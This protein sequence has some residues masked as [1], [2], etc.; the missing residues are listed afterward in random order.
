V[1][2]LHIPIMNM[3]NNYCMLLMIMFGGMK[4]IALEE[5]ADFATLD[6]KKLFSKLKS[7]ELSRKGRPNHDSSLTSKALITSAH[8]G[9]H[10]ANPANNISSSLEFSLLSLTATSDEQYESIPDDEIAPLARK[11]RTLHKFYKE[12]RWSPRGCFECS[13]TIH[14]IIDSPKRKKFD[15]SNKYDCT[16]Q[17]DSSNKADHKKNNSFRD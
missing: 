10:D 12:R 4:I 2:P 13:D 15:S 16:N 3:L 9:G 17:N 6:T 5:Y 7:H 14:F 11:F 1:V 8:V